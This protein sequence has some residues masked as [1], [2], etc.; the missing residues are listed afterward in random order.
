MNYGGSFNLDRISTQIEKL[1]AQSEADGFWNDTQAAQD[2]MK[3]ISGLKQWG[4]AWQKAATAIDDV[5]AFL[6]LAD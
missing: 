6:E 3:K 5:E 4:A 2:V 1:Q